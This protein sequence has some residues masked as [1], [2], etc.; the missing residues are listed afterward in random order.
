MQNCI[1]L[2]L[3]ICCTALL[4]SSCQKEYSNETG[5][6]QIATGTL[7]DST[8]NCL[9]D[10][11]AGTF[12]DGITPG[13]DTAFVEIQV[14]VAKTGS[15][16]IATDLQNGFE[17]ADSGFFTTTGLNIIRL[18]PIG[19]PI[20]PN[21]TLFTISFDSSFCTFNV[22]VQDSTGTGIHSGGTGIDTIPNGDP[23][24]GGA[25]QFTSGGF[26]YH[27]NSIAGL[28]KDTAGGHLLV[29]G[30]P[31]NSNDNDTAFGLIIS[32]P[33]ATP[34]PGIYV[35]TSVTNP[36]IL[37]V[38][39]NTNGVTLFEADFTTTSASV[40]VTITSYNATTKLL[41]GTFSG[42]AV[43]ENKTVHTITSGSFSVTLQ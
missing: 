4:F 38:D 37:Y 39:D 25:W 29:I 14:N 26:L 31:D 36:V 23:D 12:Y 18:K 24:A 16:S 2:L 42:T 28:V 43:D 1:R 35:T 9:P 13:G 7:K 33:N 6:T 22:N 30:T 40:T 8:G 11:V 27:S 3:I 32:I 10:S 21:S 41:K 5:A 34:A 20:L 17:F 19:T 15:Y